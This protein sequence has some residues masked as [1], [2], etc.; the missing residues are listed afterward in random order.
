MAEKEGFGTLWS[1]LRQAVGKQYATGIL[2]LILQIPI[3]WNQKEKHPLW[4]A[5]LFGGEGGI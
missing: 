5:F 3:H 4:G 2:Y 1:C